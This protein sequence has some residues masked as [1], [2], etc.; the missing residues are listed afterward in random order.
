MRDYPRTH[1]PPVTGFDGS[2]AGAT[3]SRR[4]FGASPCAARQLL[5][6]GISS[7]GPPFNTGFM[8]SLGSLGLPHLLW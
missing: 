1:Y 7:D 4:A 8:G 5:S 2:A 6:L 3:S